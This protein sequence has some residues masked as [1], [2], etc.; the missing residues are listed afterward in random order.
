DR[1]DSIEALSII[2]ATD[3][4]YGR[5]HDF[6]RSIDD[7]ISKLTKEDIRKTA[8]KYLRNPQTYIFEKKKP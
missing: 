4:L 8:I 5:S 1:T 2:T 3:E 6:Y 7:S